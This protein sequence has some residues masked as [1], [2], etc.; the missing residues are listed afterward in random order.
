MNVAIKRDVLNRL[1]FL[2]CPEPVNKE[3]YDNLSEIENCVLGILN[4]KQEKL[5]LID[6][7]FKRLGEVKTLKE[8]INIMTLAKF[9]KIG[10]KGKLD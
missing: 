5:L 9:I 2:V 10:C 8:A 1:V 6:G 4:K 3:K 7:L